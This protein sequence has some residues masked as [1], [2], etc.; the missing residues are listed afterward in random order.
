MLSLSGLIEFLLFIQ[1]MPD[2]R[3][4]R[5]ASR[6][7]VVSVMS[8]RTCVFWYRGERLLL[9]YPVEGACAKCEHEYRSVRTATITLERGVTKQI[10]PA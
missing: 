8:R 3:S 6:A 9:R 7:N 5:K 4:W 10:D 2:F 1:I